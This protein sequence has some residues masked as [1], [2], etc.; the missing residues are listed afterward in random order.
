MSTATQ[1]SVRSTIPSLILVFATIAPILGAIIGYQFS[2]N[3]EAGLLAGIVVTVALA[4]GTV[5]R[6]G[7][8]RRWYALAA[9]P[10]VFWI[11]ALAMVTTV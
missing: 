1:T 8:E 7:T 4:I 3:G 6:F 10:V 2:D 9:L 11:L 5:A